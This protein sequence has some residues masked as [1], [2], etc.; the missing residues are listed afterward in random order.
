MQLR[1]LGDRTPATPGS[2]KHR[3]CIIYRLDAQ[4]TNDASRLYP[5]I[6]FVR[7]G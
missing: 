5:N 4:R 2:E 1:G 3:M 7:V 6:I